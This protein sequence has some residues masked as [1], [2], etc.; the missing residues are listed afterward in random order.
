MEI[1]LTNLNYRHHEQNIF[2]RLNLTLEGPKIIGI[3]GEK[4]T[5]LLKLIDAI[6]LP[7]KG[8]IY[9]D[10]E[11]L[12]KD[13][14]VS[15]RRKV[16]LITQEVKDQ[17]FEST[18]ED[19]MKFLVSVM[20]YNAKD[21]TKRMKDALKMVGLDDTYLSKNMS[22]LS[23]GEQK[24]IQLAVSLLY[25]PK[26]ILLDDPMIYL[27]YP[28]KKNLIRLLKRLK[29]KY[30]K[31][32]II[33]SND[34]NFLY[35]IV[36]EVVILHHQ[37]GV[38]QGKSEEIFQNVKTLEKQHIEIPYLVT[39]TEKARAKGVRLSY[40]KDIRDIIKDIYKHVD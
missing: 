23:S 16:A 2:T 25:N 10:D 8:S 7:N 4:K 1:R 31:T 26:V 36:D 19:E 20:H 5:Q 21:L 39:F 15:F 17:F 40:H 34:S 27:D 11:K 29:E 32:I 13:N 33:A 9:L 38:I 22:T 35:P 18:V 14:L 6:N 3:M 28:R 12:Q 24:L 37:N 30:D